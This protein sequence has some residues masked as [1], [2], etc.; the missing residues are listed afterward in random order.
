ML[1]HLDFLSRRPSFLSE[2]SFKDDVT[3]V[4]SSNRPQNLTCRILV[5]TSLHSITVHKTWV[6]R[7]A[8]QEPKSR[9]LATLS[10]DRERPKIGKVIVGKTNF[11]SGLLLVIYTL[12]FLPLWPFSTF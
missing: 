4:R 11:T 5:Y 12:R 2:I 3:H 6:K 10:L 1:K 8:V 7:A 9:G